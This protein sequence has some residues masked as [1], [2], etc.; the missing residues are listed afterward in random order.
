MG[1]KVIAFWLSLAM[2][3]SLIVIVDVTMDLTLNVGGT[4]LYVNTTGSGGAYTKIQDAINASKD[5]DTVFVYSGTYYENVVVNKTINLKGED[6]DLTIIDG[7]GIGD[8]VRVIAD[9]VNI[10]GF[11]ITGSG[12]KQYNS[13]ISISPYEAP[14]VSS[15]HTIALNRIKSMTPWNVSSVPRGS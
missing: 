13:G 4:T 2:V 3:L 7:G 6:K 5:G 12:N 1:R 15:C 9:W 8:V 14:R 11:N 10:S